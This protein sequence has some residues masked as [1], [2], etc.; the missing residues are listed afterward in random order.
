[1]DPT[2]SFNE[3]VADL[4]RGGEGGLREL[5][6]RYSERLKALARTRLKGR[7]AAQGEQSDVVQSMWI[8]FVRR[9]RAGEF[10]RLGGWDELWALLA[11]ITA[12]KCVDRLRHFAALRRR[13][14]D[15]A[16]DPP[17]ER[18]APDPTPTEQA[19][20]EE[21]FER[22]LGG[23]DSRDRRIITLHLQGLDDEQIA[24][25]VGWSERTVARVRQQAREALETELGA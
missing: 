9:H 18:A 15:A 21:L 17:A 19:V 23:L 4:R 3:V 6:A 7:L 25:E 12:C 13:E 8:S 5:V 2:D 24:A 11:R 22:F 14:P 16:N 1:M 10:D 20:Y